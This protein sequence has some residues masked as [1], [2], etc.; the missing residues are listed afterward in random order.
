MDYNFPEETIADAWKFCRSPDRGGFPP[1]CFSTNPEHLWEYCG[2]A[3]C[4][5]MCLFLLFNENMK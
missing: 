2:I 1:W 5:G 3:K 4:E